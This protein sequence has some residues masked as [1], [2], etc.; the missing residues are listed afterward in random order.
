MKKLAF[1]LV[2]LALCVSTTPIVVPAAAQNYA[3]S[4]ASAPPPLLQ[5][6]REEVKPGKGPAHEKSEASWAAAYKQANLK[7]YYVGTT[8]MSGPSEAWFFS[9][10]GS[11]ED[12]EKAT[13]L[14]SANKTAQADV[15]RI[16]A[17]DGELLTG[18]RSWYAFYS[19]ELSY[20][21]NFNLGEYKYFMVDTYRIKLGHYEQFAAMRKAVNAAHEKAGLDEHMLVYNVGLGAPGGTYLVFEPMKSLKEWDEAGKTHGKGSAYYEAVG[22]DGRKMFTSF[23]RDDEQF[24]V[25]DFLAIS[26]AMSVVSEKVMAANPSFW[27]PKT[28]MAKAPA[29]KKEPMKTGKP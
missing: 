4:A 17:T 28:G 27:K 19:P 14:L 5:I 29:A 16:N 10:Y 12:A 18:A 23:L 6:F 11:M 20:R 26:P 15:D 13:A 22:D 25:R 9:A 2:V 21:P 7:Y 8:T 24:F 3:D 1:A